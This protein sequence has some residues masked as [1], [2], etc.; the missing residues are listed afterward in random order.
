L[1]VRDISEASE[2]PK[3]PS[4]S[5]YKLYSIS[6]TPNLKKF[7][8]DTEAGASLYLHGFSQYI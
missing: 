4:G 3:Q 5:S 1:G 7:V 2:T 6:F 8:S